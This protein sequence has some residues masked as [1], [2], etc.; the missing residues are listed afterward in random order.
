MKILNTLSI[1]ALATTLNA[2]CSSGGGGATPFTQWNLYWQKTRGQV[3]DLLCNEIIRV[4]GYLF[5][6]VLFYSVPDTSTLSGY[7]FD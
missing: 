3:F 5:Q 2:G 6:Q 1:L 7:D 4:D